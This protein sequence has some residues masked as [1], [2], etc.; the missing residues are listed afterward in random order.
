MTTLMQF[1]SLKVIVVAMLTMALFYAPVAKAAHLELVPVDNCSVELQE[2]VTER[3]HDDDHDHGDHAHQC[4]QCH[5][6]I[7]LID[8]F[9][10]IVA[11]LKFDKIWLLL[12]DE[13]PVTSNSSHFRPPRH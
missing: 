9:P 13:K 10:K 3:V 7:H 6:H 4:G 2:T 12:N 8:Q 11:A 5:T 1:L